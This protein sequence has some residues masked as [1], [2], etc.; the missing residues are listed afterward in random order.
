MAARL[1]GDDL[2]V[3]LEAVQRV[4]LQP[5]P[6]YHLDPLPAVLA[7]AAL[8]VLLFAAFASPSAKQPNSLPW[9]V[10]PTAGWLSGALGVL[11]WLG[12]RFIQWKGRWELHTSRVPLIEIDGEGNAIQRVELVEHK[13]IPVNGNN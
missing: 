11:W 10:G 3:Q 8:A 7:T 5:S 4:G 12:L 13:R 1:R 9:W 6:R 2:A